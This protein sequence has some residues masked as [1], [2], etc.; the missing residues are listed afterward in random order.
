MARRPSRGVRLAAAALLAL[1]LPLLVLYAW[2][3]VAVFSRRAVGL[4]PA[5]GLTI[6]HWARLLEP[7]AGATLRE[8]LARSFLLPLMLV[9]HLFPTLSAGGHISSSAPAGPHHHLGDP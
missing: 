3:P 6:Y 2:L 4:R 5:E 8:S 7:I 1:M 9:L